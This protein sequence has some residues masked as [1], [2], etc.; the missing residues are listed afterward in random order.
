M[1]NIINNYPDG[2]AEVRNIITT[3]H[4]YIHKKDIFS[5]GLKLMHKFTG[6]GYH[7]FWKGL[8]FNPLDS[9]TSCHFFNTINLGRN[10]WKVHFETTLPRLG[11]APKFVYDVAIKKLASKNCEQIIALSTCTYKLQIKYLEKNYPQYLEVI[12]S[13]MIVQLPPQK[14]LIKTYNEKILSTNKIIFTIV[15]SDFFRKGGLE[16]LQVFENLIPSNKELFL[17]IVSTMNFGDYA[18]RTETRHLKRAQNIIE[19][20]PDNIKHFKRL[21]NDDV[22]ELFK[23][24]HVGLLPTWADSFGYSILEAQA[25]GCPVITTDI[26]AI[27]EINS[28]EMGWVITVPK[29]EDRNGAL[30]TENERTVFASTVKKELNQIVL[31]IIK[32]KDSIKNKGEKALQNI[33]NNHEKNS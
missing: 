19:K 18:T 11:D 28:N 27:P 16:V 30:A 17:N 10:P 26:R 8:F 22:L 6:K 14:S 5:L 7:P 32:N 3:E 29:D 4:N 25:C 9:K 13:K 2:Y 33:K 23:A 21:K 15:G 1:K 12:K 31:D 20:F 24:S